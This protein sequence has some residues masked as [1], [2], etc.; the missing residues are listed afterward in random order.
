MDTVISESA[1]QIDTK[2]SITYNEDEYEVMHR[3]DCANFVSQCLKAGGIA[4]KDSWH[5]YKKPLKSDYT[6]SWSAAKEQYEYFNNPYRGYRQEDVGEETIQ[7]W[8]KQGIACNKDIIKE[9]D[10][11]Y[12]ADRKNRIITHAAIV[13]GIGAGN[14][15]YYAAHSRPNAYEPLSDHFDEY[16]VFVI[17][18]RD[19]A[20]NGY[21]DD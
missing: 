5:Y 21:C 13:S 6:I 18:I 7:L 12:F 8:S 10:L 2:C 9:G 1:V 20:I 17:R 19:D 16:M 4:M 11:I 14:E 3:G 15:I